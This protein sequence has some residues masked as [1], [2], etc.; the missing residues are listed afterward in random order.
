MD[1]RFSDRSLENLWC[2]AVV[3]FVFQRPHLLGGVLSGLN[4]KMAGFLTFLEEKGFWTGTGGETILLASQNMINADKI[5]LKGLGPN[6]DYDTKILVDRMREVSSTLDKI[7]INEFGIYIPTLEGL[8]AEYPA[9]LEISVLHLV[10]SF[11]ENHR[12]ESHFLLKIIFSIERYLTSDLKPMMSR[13]RDHFFSRLDFSIILD[14]ET[15]N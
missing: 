6:S 1:L 15:K 2:Q 8:E 13:L 12:N 4:E 14:Q 3:A 10:D 11:L 5:L 7:D 9:Y